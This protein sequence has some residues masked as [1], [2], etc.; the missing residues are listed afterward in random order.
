MV[1]LG[2]FGKQRQQSVHIKIFK[3]SHIEYKSDM[4]VSYWSQKSLE[5]LYGH[6]IEKIQSFWCFIGVETIIII[7]DTNF[8]LSRLASL[9]DFS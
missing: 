1:C 7:K 3:A 6:E 4:Q 5:I 2:S 9:S 8:L